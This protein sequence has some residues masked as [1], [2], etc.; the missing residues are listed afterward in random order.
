MSVESDASTSEFV[1][2]LAILLLAQLLSA[3]QGAYTEETYAQYKADWTENLFYSHFLSLAL[4]L[5]VSGTL[6]RQY[7]KLAATTPLDLRAQLLH[8]SRASAHSSR[9]RRG[10]EMLCAF[11]E[12]TPRGVLFLFTNAVTQLACISGVSLLAAKSS[13]VTVT[14]VLNIR[15]L[16]SF[17]LSMMLFGH[18]LNTKMVI[19]SSLVFGSGAIYG[20]ETSWRLPRERRRRAQGKKNGTVPGEAGREK[21]A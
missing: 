7:Q 20:W 9:V 11:L 13:A 14:I 19:G 6:R 12:G 8:G 17:I 1:T 18:D 10:L 16:V 3:F 2:G 15:K 5:P 4:F 21:A